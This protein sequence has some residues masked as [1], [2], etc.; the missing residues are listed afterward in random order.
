MRPRPQRGMDRLGRRGF[1]RALPRSAR[2]RLMVCPQ[3]GKLVRSLLKARRAGPSA[4]ASTAVKAKSLEKKKKKKPR[5]K[6]S[7]AGTKKAP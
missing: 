4:V 7:K 2:A 1:N 6:N 3:L 5:K